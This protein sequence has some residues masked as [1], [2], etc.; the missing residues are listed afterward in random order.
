ME[1]HE[2]KGWKAIQMIYVEYQRRLFKI[3]YVG[4]VL[5]IDLRLLQLLIEYNKETSEEFMTLVSL[6][7]W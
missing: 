3:Q 6:Q 7:D 5:L 2:M 1:N 4:N